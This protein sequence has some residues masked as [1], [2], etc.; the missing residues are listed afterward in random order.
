LTGMIPM[1]SARL[2]GISGI[3]PVKDHSPGC[4]TDSVPFSKQKI[5]F[6]LASGNARG[7]FAMAEWPLSIFRKGHGGAWGFGR[8]VY[9]STRRTP[10]L[11]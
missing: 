2:I 3:K 11:F 7:P 5:F 10:I 1:R 9:R 6:F 8:G 4:R